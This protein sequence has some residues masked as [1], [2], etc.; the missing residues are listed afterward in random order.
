MK[1]SK[2]RELFGK[3]D[4]LISGWIM[5]QDLYLP[6]EITL[7]SISIMLDFNCSFFNIIKLIEYAMS[8]NV[9]LKIQCQQFGKQ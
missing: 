6:V 5:R 4:I 2:S 3:S 7:I 9:F 1:V 8:E